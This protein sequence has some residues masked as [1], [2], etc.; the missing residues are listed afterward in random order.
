MECE[1]CGKRIVAGTR[2]CTGCWL[3]AETADHLAMAQ[4]ERRG[5]EFAIEIAIAISWTDR[6]VR[7]TWAAWA[8]R[9]KKYLKR[10]L[11][12]H[13]QPTG[14]TS[15]EDRLFKDD[16][17][18]TRLE[19]QGWTADNI[20]E[21]DRDRSTSWIARWREIARQTNWATRWETSSA[22]SWW[23]TTWWSWWVD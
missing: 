12:K 6:G 20:S 21:A 7:D 13:G 3:P 16:F 8:H 22:G 14:Y 4:A 2:I 18:R 9:M 11:K 15:I 19:V 5:Q 10:A 17:F 1:Q 23:G